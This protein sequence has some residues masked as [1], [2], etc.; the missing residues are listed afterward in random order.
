MRTTSRGGVTMIIVAVIIICITIG[1]FYTSV[2]RKTEKMENG[3]LVP[4]K[5]ES[6]LNITDKYTPL[7]KMI[8]KKSHCNGTVEI[9]EKW[10]DDKDKDLLTIYEEMNRV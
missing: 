9:K 1:T 7:E 3:T 8:V 5:R 2:K 4:I 6:V 10:N